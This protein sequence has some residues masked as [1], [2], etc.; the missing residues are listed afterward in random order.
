MRLAI[1]VVYPNL[2]PALRQAISQL[3]V[4]EWVC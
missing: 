3:P 4:A 1:L 2:Y